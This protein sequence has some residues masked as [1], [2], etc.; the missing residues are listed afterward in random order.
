VNVVEIA[1]N[2][3]EA[4]KRMDNQG[5]WSCGDD[6]FLSKYNFQKLIYFVIET[7][8]KISY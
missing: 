6:F 3:V 8:L 2:Y 1:S 4:E 7:N 5:M